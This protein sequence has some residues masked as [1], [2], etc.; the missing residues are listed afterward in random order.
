M[1]GGGFEQLKIYHICDCCDTIYKVTETTAYGTKD[2]DLTGNA[3][4]DIMNNEPEN[5]NAYAAGICDECRDEMYG[6]VGG[7]VLPYRLH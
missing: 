4:G 6:S 7:I 1:K 2:T 5:G 3:A